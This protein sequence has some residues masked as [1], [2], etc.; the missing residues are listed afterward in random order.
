M[1][2]NSIPPKEPRDS[3]QVSPQKRSHDRILIE[4]SSPLP[5]YPRYSLAQMTNNSAHKSYLEIPPYN[6]HHKLNEK[7]EDIVKQLVQLIEQNKEED[8]EKLLEN[9]I[10]SEKNS[11]FIIGEF[12][13]VISTIPHI[14]QYAGIL[15]HIS[16]I[17]QVVWTENDGVLSLAESIKDKAIAMRPTRPETQYDPLKSAAAGLIAIGAGAVTIAGLSSIAGPAGA[18][19]PVARELRADQKKRNRARNKLNSAVFLLENRLTKIEALD[20]DIKE[21]HEKIRILRESLGGKKHLDTKDIDK[22]IATAE[23]LKEQYEAKRLAFERQA[24]ALSYCYRSKV[25]HLKNKVGELTQHEFDFEKYRT[26]YKFREKQR[27]ISRE[28][29]LKNKEK[30]SLAK[31]DV[32][33]DKLAITSLTAASAGL[34]LAPFGP[35]AVI[36]Y[37]ISAATGLSAAFRKIKNTVIKSRKFSKASESQMNT[38]YAEITANHEKTAKLDEMIDNLQHKFWQPKGLTI[39]AKDRRKLAII[40]YHLPEDYRSDTKKINDL[41]HPLFEHC[42]NKKER[43]QLIEGL[44]MLR[45]NELILNNYFKKSPHLSRQDFTAKHLAFIVNQEMLKNNKDDSFIDTILNFFIRR[46]NKRHSLG[47]DP[48]SHKEKSTEKFDI[49]VR[50][51]SA[52]NIDTVSKNTH[53]EAQERHIC[54]KEPTF[55]AV[56]EYTSIHGPAFFHTC[57]DCMKIK[58]EDNNSQDGDEPHHE[59]KPH[60]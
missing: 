15:K 29:T 18:I 22:E 27:W 45:R 57:P 33:T 44:Y 9:V 16:T 24:I 12:L 25:H 30:E 41:L 28:L 52:Q 21:T 26:D 49:S 8:F 36:A 4:A 14:Q 13:N 46:R 40:L 1:S 32:K 54:G 31:S 5:T 37:A 51:L 35:P 2:K 48:S 59:E 47:S 58:T 50:E 53:E 43:S 23:E 60:H 11:L 10:K 19:L 20:K 56:K 55:P 17:F 3:H 42:K 38:F 6:Q 39:N 34:I 7:E